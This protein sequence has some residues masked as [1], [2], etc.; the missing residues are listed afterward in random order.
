MLKVK[1]HERIRSFELELSARSSGASLAQIVAVYRENVA[2]QLN[3][4]GKRGKRGKT[5]KT[6]N[7][8][9]GGKREWSKER[10]NGVME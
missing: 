5:G 7:S 1:N 4:E 6:G 10:E 3:G 9:L 2:F 8:K